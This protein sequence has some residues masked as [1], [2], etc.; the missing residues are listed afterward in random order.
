MKQPIGK[1]ESAGN[2]LKIFANERFKSLSALSDAS[3][4]KIQRLNQY[5]M[6]ISE[7]DMN[8]LE[9][10]AG[11]GLNINWLL[12]GKGNMTISSG[13]GKDTV[14][15]ND[16]HSAE[17]ADETESDSPLLLETNIDNMDSEIFPYVIDRLLAAGAHDAYLTPIIMKKGRPAIMLSALV[18][19]ALL[20]TALEIIYKET[21]TLGVR[22][23]T[24]A[25]KKLPR[26]IKN[27]ST[28][29][30]EIA[31]KEIH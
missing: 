3:G 31:I 24:I 4:I 21:P 20:D 22:V 14:G 7:P 27:V 10:F 6:D 25:R 13:A 16:A 1:K 5:V 18:P 15:A 11:L 9:K 17:I 19:S 2:R 28:S 26:K 8:T 23:Q 12:T 30:G 29:F